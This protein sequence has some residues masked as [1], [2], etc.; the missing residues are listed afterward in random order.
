MKKIALM[1]LVGAIAMSSLA[2]CSVNTT[3]KDNS[4]SKPED[5]SAVVSTEASTEE[6]K[7]EESKAEES[8]AEAINL[9]DLA[10]ELKTKLVATDTLDKPTD[11]LYNDTGIVDTTFNNYVWFSEMSGLS[12]EMVAI[13]EAKS[14]A[15]VTAIKGFLDGYLQSVKNQMKDYNADNYDM[16]TKAVIKTSGLYVYIVISPNVTE[17]DSMIAAKLA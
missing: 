5:S 10:A 16:A 7:A 13:F 9:I 6:S 14:E 1:L 8:K 17:I 11:E 12:S 3:D 2:A 4:S 15:D